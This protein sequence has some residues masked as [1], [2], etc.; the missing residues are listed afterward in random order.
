M[1]GEPT[2]LI[3]PRTGDSAS[4]LAPELDELIV[5]E[6]V[7]RRRDA[8]RA[9]LLAEVHTAGLTDIAHG[10]RTPMW[11]A[12]VCDL[13]DNTA[14]TLVRISTRLRDRFGPLADAL[15]AG[16]IGWQHVVVFDRLA[17]PRIINEL[18]EL[19]PELLVL[20]DIATFERWS[21]ELR[22]I[23]ERLDQNGG[24]DPANDTRN[25]ELHLTPTID[26]YTHVSGRLVGELAL[27]IRSLIN[28]EADRVMARHRCDA[29]QCGDTNNLASYANARAEALA[30]LLERG[31]TV[32]DGTGRLIE[33][34]LVVTY[35]P[36]T[37][38]LTD[39]TG[40]QLSLT[41]LRWLIAAAMIRPLELTDTGDPLRMGHALR[42]ANRH[43]RRALAIRDGGCIFPGCTRPPAWCDA[44]HVDH[45]NHNHP[46][47]GGTTDIENLALL[48]RHHHRVT[49]RPGW[50]MQ[51]WTHPEHTDTILFRWH[52]PTGRIIYSQ[53]HGIRWNAERSSA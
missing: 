21:Q 39:N 11:L 49:H 17:N 3:K 40:E 18:V 30:E 32:P 53:R 35:Q 36:D 7:Q 22:G 41:V 52:T 15:H 38:K 16:R 10:Q 51:Q 25:N 34:E 19:L 48:C 9:E 46:E 20:A 4:W 28:T 5:W 45:W 12:D 6:A 2:D 27:M 42:Y 26:G 1:A 8:R 50:S 37:N 24:Y 13:P 29:E 14:R 44:H 43:Q 33:P 31:A 47:H 23:V